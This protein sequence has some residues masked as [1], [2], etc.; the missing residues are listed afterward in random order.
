MS[1]EHWVVTPDAGAGRELGPSGI[2]VLPTAE[3][4]D[5]SVA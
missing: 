2:D 4:I 5:G 1:V 3:L